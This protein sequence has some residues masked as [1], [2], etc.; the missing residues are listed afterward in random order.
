MP[1]CRA[2]ACSPGVT[3]LTGARLRDQAECERVTAEITRG[4][5]RLGFRRHQGAVYF[6]SP[7]SEV[8]EEQR[9]VLRRRLA[10]L[11]AS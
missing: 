5:E 3:D 1:G 10:E 9:D 11:G 8:L 7:V 6:L 4:W 2:I